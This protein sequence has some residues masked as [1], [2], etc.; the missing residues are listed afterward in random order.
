M[1]EVESSGNLGGSSKAL[2]LGGLQFDVMAGG[3]RTPRGLRQ[4]TSQ[5]AQRVNAAH[6]SGSEPRHT[7]IADA[8][9]AG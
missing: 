4:S 9:A 7:S 6:R 8:A 1:G 5:S 2:V 3:V